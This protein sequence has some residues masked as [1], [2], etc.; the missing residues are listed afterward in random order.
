MYKTKKINRILLTTMIAGLTTSLTTVAVDAD[1]ALPQHPAF[2]LAAEFPVDGSAEII[3]ATPNGK[4]LVYTDAAGHL[5]FVDITNPA[6]PGMIGTVN[7]Q[8]DGVGEPTSV[9]ITDDGRFAVVAVR[10][11][12]DADHANP[13]ILRVYDI[14]NLKRIALVKEVSVGIG[15]DAIALA[16][17][18]KTL[19][20]VVAIEDEETNRDGDATTPGVRPGRIDVVGLQD[21]YGAT[22]TGLQSLDLVPALVGAGVDYPTDPQPEFV[23]V[24]QQTMQAAVTLQ[25]NNAIAIVDLS[26]PTTPVLSRVFS[27]GTVERINSADLTK[28]KEIS[29][30]ESFT[31]R[32][33][34]D[35]I[36]WVDNNTLALANEGDTWV[37]DDG[38]F[39]GTRGFTLMD[40]F[41]NVIHETGAKTE[42]RAV[43]HGHYPDSRSAKKGVEIESVTVGTYGATPCLFVG[44]ERGS[45]VE[46]YRV[47]NP[48]SP[49]FV[50]LLPTGMAPEGLLTITGR[51]DHKQLFVSANEADG[52]ITI[53]HYSDYRPLKNFKEPQLV[54]IDGSI[55]WGALSGLTTDGVRMYAVPDNAFKH[56]RIYTI[57][58][59]EVR[60]GKMIVEAVTMLTTADGSPLTVDPEGIARVADGF[61]IAAEG[62]RVAGNELIKV[63]FDGVVME[64]VALPAAVQAKFSSPTVS[65]GFEGVTASSDGKTL[66]VALQRGFN[67]TLPFAA[68]LKYETETGAWTSALYPLDQHSKNPVTL[69][70]GL[71]EILLTDD[72]RLLVLER[73]KGGGENGAI[74]AEIKRIYS[75]EAADV[76][77]GAVLDKTLVSDLRRQYNYLQ[78]KVE[79][80]VIHNQTLWVVNDND[81][82]GWSRMVRVGFDE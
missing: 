34:P 35:G 58:P 81:G 43:R 20:A 41:G 21:L 71:S 39:P 2:T 78:E 17:G 73:D 9:A 76:I 57:D 54:A 38:V 47:D 61:W 16:G 66:Y 36:A 37:S 29:L 31:G 46:V 25:E 72:G 65:T 10:L 62:S 8:K 64:R 69:W 44:S 23:A 60:Q 55:P 7:V 68:I 3:A 42:E 18:G 40:T 32:R 12:D 75:V 48:A 13:G 19:R 11:G 33:E 82:A 14:G 24:N 22:S 70:T 53:Y 52:S 80:M 79:G 67:P 56:S 28:D 45:F 63:G 15:P 51:A 5:G 77:E 4:T 30:T 6:K 27:A 50:Q 1:A 74:T 26:D 49:Q 59:S